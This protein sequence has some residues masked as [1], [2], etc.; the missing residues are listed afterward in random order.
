MTT[1]T[2]P[3][4]S[5]TRKAALLALLAV[6]VI[7]GVYVIHRLDT[8]PRTDDAYAYA[9]TINVAPEVSGYIVELPVRDNQAVKKGDVLFV[10][11]PGPHRET[12]AKAKAGM[13]VLDEEIRQASKLVTAQTFTANAAKEALEQAEVAVRQARSSYERLAPLKTKGYASAERVDQARSALNAAIAQRN[14]AVAQAA[15]AEAAISSVDALVARRNVALADIALAEINLEHTVVRA[16][17]DGIIASLRTSAGAFVA[18]GR[19]VFTL[20]NTEEWYVVA[21][22]RETE[23]NAITA[24]RAAT[25]YLLADSSRRFAATVDSVGFGVLPDD[26]GVVIEGLPIVKRSI[27]WVRVAQRFPVKFLVRDPDPALF[28]VGASAVAILQDSD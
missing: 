6:A 7:L 28:R 22:F 4:K 27:N 26:G 9:P 19:P 18:A 10:I 24:G 23:L 21:N 15:G 5:G 3:A 12:L 2:P 13:V 8:A 17:C 20:I 25:V 11:D 16:P 1:K 14:A